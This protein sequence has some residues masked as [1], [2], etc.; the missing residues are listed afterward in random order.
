MQEIDRR[1]KR[2]RDKHRITLINA[3]QQVQ[4][5]SS[6]YDRPFVYLISHIFKMISI[7]HMDE[8]CLFQFLIR[9]VHLYCSSSAT[10]LISYN[11]V[12]SIY[13][14]HSCPMSRLRISY[15]NTYRH[16]RNCC[17][18]SSSIDGYFQSSSS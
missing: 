1:E 7:E 10:P 2:K 16:Y 5:I 18:P 17:I 3:M 14:L 15:R 9:R 8:H 11:S 4:T 6:G 12:H 13:P